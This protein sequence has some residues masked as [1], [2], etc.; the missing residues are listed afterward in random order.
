MCS[1]EIVVVSV[2]LIRNRWRCK[3]R[4]GRGRVL[5]C[6]VTR[7]FDINGRYVLLSV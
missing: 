2:G 3:R 4:I 6:V 7:G 1:A 5:F